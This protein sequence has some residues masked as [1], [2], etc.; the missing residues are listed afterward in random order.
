MRGALV[1]AEI[2]PN[3]GKTIMEMEMG[4]GGLLGSPV[5]SG[6][7]LLLTG[8]WIPPPPQGTKIPQALLCGKNKKKVCSGAGDRRDRQ[9]AISKRWRQMDHLRL[10]ERGPW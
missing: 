8:A 3:Q 2:I 9:A 4:G 7:V 1:Q 10:R 6:S 5:A